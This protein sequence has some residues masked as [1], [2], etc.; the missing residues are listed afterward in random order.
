MFLFYQIQ[1]DD[2]KPSFLPQPQDNMAGSSLGDQS[3][4]PIGPWATGRVDWSP[5]GGLTGTRP[6]VDHYSITRYSDAEWRKH[7]EEILC[8]STDDLHRV[9][10]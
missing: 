7:N 10:M 3:L 8:T 5:L 1:N 9:N 4:T 2:E 6:V